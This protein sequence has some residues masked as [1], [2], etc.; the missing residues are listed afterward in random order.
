MDDFY[1]ELNPQQICYLQDL[2][3]LVYFLY[4]LF[5]EGEL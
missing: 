2:H 5:N 3:F 4:K 1:N